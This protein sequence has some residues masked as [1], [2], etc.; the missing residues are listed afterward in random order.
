MHLRVGVTIEQAI[1]HT[2]KAK[3]R[4]ALKAAVS[5]EVRDGIGVPTAAYAARLVPMTMTARGAGIALI[6]DGAIAIVDIGPNG[7]RSTVIPASKIGAV[8]RVSDTYGIRTIRITTSD[9]QRTELLMRDQSDDFITAA[10]QLVDPARL[11]GIPWWRL[12]TVRYPK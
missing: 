9:D 10:E 5:D 7:D 11:G 6:S 4:D 8:T 12:P 3:H 1:D 2:I